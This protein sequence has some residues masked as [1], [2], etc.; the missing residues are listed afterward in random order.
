MKLYEID[1]AI[2]A[3]VDGETGEVIDPEKLDAL[4]LERDAKVEGVVLWYKELVATAD[5]IKAEREA[6]EEREKRCRNKAEGIKAWLSKALDSQP[7]AT[8]RCEVRWRKS[9]RVDV[10]DPE[11]IPGEYLTQEIKYKANKTAI[12]AAIKAGGTVPGCELVTV[13]NA[14]I[15]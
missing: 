13:S 12:K 2:L 8:A 15:K 14:Q 1:N 5:A 11:H 9:E 6:L 3:C 4:T 7:F 10:L